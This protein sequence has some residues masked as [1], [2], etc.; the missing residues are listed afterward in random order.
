MKATNLTT[1][2]EQWGGVE[3]AAQ[4]LF[5]TSKALSSKESSVQSSSSQAKQDKNKE[6]AEEGV[7]LEISDEA[8][9]KYI[10]QMNVL[11]Q[12]KRMAE[13]NRKQS[14]KQAEE[15]D[16]LGKVMTIFRRIANGDIVPYQDERKLME[17][18]KEM[19]MA[20]KNIASMK[21]NEDPEKYDS[22][23]KNKKKSLLEIPEEFKRSSG[24]ETAS[25]SSI[26]V[27]V[28]ETGGK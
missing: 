10:E 4:K 11:D 26:A 13:E 8:K 17:Y 27:A 12:L 2:I 18:N 21:E 20:A 14:K 22:V 25:S 19:Y 5:G 15:G 23:D 3:T 7:T 16:E 1:E 24:E 6:N 28:P 9:K